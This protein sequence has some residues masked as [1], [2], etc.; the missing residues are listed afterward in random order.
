MRAP[1]APFAYL[2]YRYFNRCEQDPA[3]AEYM[4]AC[5]VL[6]LGAGIVITILA[7]KGIIRHRTSVSRSTNSI[8]ERR[9]LRK[10]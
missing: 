4:P 3:G 10:T 9:I 2:C 6:G 7:F 5:S 1:Y 8:S